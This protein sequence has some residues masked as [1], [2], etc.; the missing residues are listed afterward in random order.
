MT[1]CSCSIIEILASCFLHFS[2]TS[3]FSL[4]RVLTFSESMVTCEDSETFSLTVRCAVADIW[5]VETLRNSEAT[6]SSLDIISRF[7]LRPKIVTASGF[8]IC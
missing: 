1:D 2:L 4:E 3:P 5:A 7:N 8:P 6:F